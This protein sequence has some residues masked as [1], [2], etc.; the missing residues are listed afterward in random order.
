[1]IHIVELSD[2]FGPRRFEPQRFAH[3]DLG[4]REQGIPGASRT[5]LGA[6]LSGTGTQD[7][8]LNFASLAPFS[9]QAL[10]IVI[11]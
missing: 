5:D 3:G 10:V 4:C 2:G 7:G 6:P 11:P 1:M 9:K 8:W